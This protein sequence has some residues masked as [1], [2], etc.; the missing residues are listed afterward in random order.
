MEEGPTGE[1]P[2][3]WILTSLGLP[4]PLWGET[5]VVAVGKLRHGRKMG[6]AAA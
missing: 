4:D 1:T 6:G 3:S 2:R 5:A